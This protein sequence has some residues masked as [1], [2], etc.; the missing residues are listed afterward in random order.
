MNKT[1]FDRNLIRVVLICFLAPIVFINFWIGEILIIY[2]LIGF[3]PDK[4]TY[5]G[6][7]GCITESWMYPPI[8]FSGLIIDF[9]IIISA[10]MLSKKASQ[11]NK[12]NLTL[13]SAFLFYPVSNRW[14]N[15]IIHWLKENYFGFIKRR[16]YLEEQH[17]SF[18]GNLYNYE[19]TE[20]I[21]H[22]IVSIFYLL[23]AYQIIFNHWEKKIRIQ[24]FTFG[25]ASCLAGKLFWHF[26]L[27]PMI[28]R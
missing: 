7:V 25:L 21:F 16:A 27:G 6:V 10:Y 24:F 26:F 17:L 4:V 28:Y 14:V 12:I 1:L 22:T 8:F 9:V 5:Y 20:F 3:I 11:N 15:E 18:F 19:W 13:F 23:L 2:N